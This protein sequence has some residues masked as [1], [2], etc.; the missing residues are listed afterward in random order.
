MLE[1]HLGNNEGIHRVIVP[2][3]SGNTTQGRSG[4]HRSGPVS[5]LHRIDSEVSRTALYSRLKPPP[6]RLYR[7]LSFVLLWTTAKRVGRGGEKSRG[8]GA[9]S[10]S[11]GTE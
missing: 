8:G 4:C 5:A 7:S 6:C 3:S 1:L 10:G 2:I 11:I 9:L